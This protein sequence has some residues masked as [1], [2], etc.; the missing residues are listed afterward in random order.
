MAHTPLFGRLRRLAAQVLWA[1][2]RGLQSPEQLRAEISSRAGEGREAEISRRGLARAAA[3]VL[4]GPALAACARDDGDD[5]DILNGEAR[6]VV[7]GAGLAGIHCAYRLAEA[8]VNVVVYEAWNRIGGRTFS[9]SEGAPAGMMIELG[10]EL[11]DSNHATLWTLADELGITLDDRFTLAPPGETFF[12]GGTAVDEATILSQWMAVAPSMVTMVEAADSDDAAYEQYDNQTLRAWLDEHVP[13]ATYPELHVIL[14]VA[15]RGEFGLENDEQS[16]LNLLY[17]MDPETLDEFRIF[18]D[19]D[20]RWNANGG[21]QQFVTRMAEV[22][23]DE[24][25]LLDRR[26]VAAREGDGG[27]YVLTFQDT[28]GNMTDVEAEHVVFALPFTTLRECDLTGLTLSNTKRQ[29]IA[30]LGY[31]TNTKIMG[32]FSAPIWRD[33]F[34]ASGTVTSDLPFQQCW[35]SS[36]GQAGTEG[37]IANFLGGDAGVD[38]GTGSAEQW[39]TTQVLPGL[40]Q[41]FPGTTALYVADSA[42]RMHWPSVPTHK[43][44]Y[45]CYRP[46]QWATWALEG[47]RE[48]NLHFCGEHCSPEF[49]GWMEGAAETGGLV[50]M[51][52]IDDLGASAS[53]RHVELVTRAT[54]LVPHPCYHGDLAPRLRWSTRRRLLR[55]RFATHR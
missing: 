20:E 26:L 24:Q 51:E 3:S 36:I 39:Y 50:A 2:R 44:S 13:I 28:D 49:Q 14:D 48:G 46:G 35:D 34:D 54:Q 23:T 17:L 32:T 10:G 22:L 5:D 31:G 30:E 4:A 7:V 52:I 29:I 37:I 6:V 43:G 42:V 55:Q 47:V 1:H 11:I 12:I 27:G 38:S 18:G 9:T 41:V 45:T 16:A 19:S 33:D 15:Y 21:S 53:A 25:L 8:G 40:E